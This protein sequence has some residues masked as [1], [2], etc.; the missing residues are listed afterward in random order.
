MPGHCP[1]ITGSPPLR[2]LAAAVTA[3]AFAAMLVS[4]TGLGLPR[5]LA[6]GSP[7]IAVAGVH[8]SGEQKDDALR[9]LA[10]DLEAALGSRFVAAGP[11]ALFERFLPARSQVLDTVFLA[12]ARDSLRE[13][14]IH[15]E[16][17]RFDQAVEAFRRAESALAGNLEFVHDQRLLVDI[18]LY[19]GLSYASMGARDDAQEAF[20]EVVRLAPDRVLDTLEYPPKIVSA[21]EDVRD[22]ILARDGASVTVSAPAGTR[23]YV[24][25]RRVGEGSARVDDLPPGFHVL[26]AEKDGAG[27]QFVELILEEGEQ[28]AVDV[29]LSF[30]GLTREGDPF[31]SARSGVTKRLYEEIA[32][33]S[34][35]DLVVIAAFDPDGNLQLGLYSTRSDTF[36]E[37]VEASLAA[38]PGKRAA[39]VDQLV[40]RLAAFADTSGAIVGDRVSATVPEVSLGENPVL[41][42]LLFQEPPT[43]TVASVEPT[44]EAPA[45]TKKERKPVN[46]GAVVGVI[47]GIL[48]AG[49]AATGIYFA[50]RPAPEPVGT[51]QIAI[52]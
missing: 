29:E 5:A 10:G 38:S 1:S 39:F 24:D 28:R 18:S 30:L 12:P 6:Q 15:Y 49:G 41:D 52:P 17:A 42:D 2:R 4:P 20:G 36:S 43:A 33:V 34:G 19:L 22:A 25:G 8:G 47:L 48:G 50:V 16:S 32:R 23:L 11:D 13:G 3:G 46:P 21:F 31:E 35:T 40:E 51:L 14:R 9:A 26:L 44:D 27:R 45:A 7:S 37:V